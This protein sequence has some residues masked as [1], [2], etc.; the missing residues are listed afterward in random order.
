[1]IWETHTQDLDEWHKRLQS[2]LT[3]WRLV[4][5]P[6][7][8]KPPLLCETIS[9]PAVF[10]RCG[11]GMA[12]IGCACLKKILFEQPTQIAPAVLHAFTPPHQVAGEETQGFKVLREAE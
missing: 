1:M 3:A 2:S 7:L 6:G 5:L 8:K 10:W 11:V 12:S 4:S 9:R